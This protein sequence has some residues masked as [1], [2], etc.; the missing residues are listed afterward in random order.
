MKKAA[1]ASRSRM[2]SIARSQGSWA[3]LQ[4]TTIKACA[5]PGCSSAQDRGSALKSTTTL[6][7]PEASSRGRR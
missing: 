5:P 2:P 3:Y 4:N 6:G 1:R 7:T